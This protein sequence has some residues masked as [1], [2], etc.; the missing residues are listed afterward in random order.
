MKY[1]CYVLHRLAFVAF[2]EIGRIKP[3]YSG[4]SLVCRY[5]ASPLPF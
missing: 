3:V 2:T 1:L 4:M 5:K